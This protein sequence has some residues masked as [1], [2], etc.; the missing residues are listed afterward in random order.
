MAADPTLARGAYMAARNDS[1]EVRE[2]ARYLNKSIVDGIDKLKKPK[3]EEDPSLQNNVVETV[4]KKTTQNEDPNKTDNSNTTE[5]NLNKEK[6]KKELTFDEAFAKARKELGPGKTFTYKG[7]QYSTNT[8]SDLENQ[9]N[10]AALELDGNTTTE[11]NEVIEDELQVAKDKVNEALIAGDNT[12]PEQAMRNLE[13]NADDISVYQETIAQ[14]GQDWTNRSKEGGAK[15]PYGYGMAL[16]MDDKN[17]EWLMGV[18]NSKQRLEVDDSDKDNPRYG[19]YGPDDNFMTP[20]QLREYLVQFEV[21]NNSFNQLDD[22]TYNYKDKGT[23][24]AATDVFDYDEAKRSVTQIVDN[25]N[26]RSLTFDPTFGGTSYADDLING[27]EMGQITYKSLGIDPPA[28]DKDGIINEEDNINDDLKKQIMKQWTAKDGP[29]FEKYRNS[30]IDYYTRHIQKN[31]EFGRNQNARK[32]PNTP[33]VLSSP[34]AS[35]QDLID[36]YS[37]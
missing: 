12:T 37:V 19:V 30:V 10:N 36:K 5:K 21:D 26:L 11:E 1:S 15:T 23:K 35:A 6:K 7:E 20:K 8:A 14:L 31:F 32:V 25:G 29:H 22:L 24:S 18:I 3:E 34:T 13:R 17:K 27:D 4:D 9:T 16:E 33:L 28:D 2:A